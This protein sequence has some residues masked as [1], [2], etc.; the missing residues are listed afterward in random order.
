MGPRLRGDDGGKK[1]GR[2]VS[3]PAT[4]TNFVFAVFYCPAP[5]LPFLLFLLL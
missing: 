5:L 4:I 3:L 1:N 2:M